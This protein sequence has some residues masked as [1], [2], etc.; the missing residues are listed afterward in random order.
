MKKPERYPASL[1]PRLVAKNHAPII[2]PTNR[3][4]ATFVIGRVFMKHFA[5]GGTLLD[6]NPPDYKEFIKAQQEKVASK[7]GRGK[8][9]SAT[10]G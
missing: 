6:F 7:F 4:G 8:S 5:S 2:S 9:G 10:Q 3:A 1:F